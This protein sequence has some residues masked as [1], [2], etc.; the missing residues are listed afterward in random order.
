MKKIGL[1]F[2]MFVLLIL[3]YSCGVDGDP[4]H[5]YFSLEWEYYAEDY[6][7][8]YYRDNNPDVPDGADIVEKQYYDCYP[9]SYDYYYESE[10]PENWYTFE[11]VYNLVQNLGAPARIFEDGVDGVDTFFDLYLFVDP[12]NV[13]RMAVQNPPLKLLDSP[14]EF[15]KAD[16]VRVEDLSWEVI[17]DGWTLSV[18]Q[19]VSV[20][21]KQIED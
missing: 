13:Q 21:K 2:T 8:S 4:G 12:F 3:S 15:L 18:T 11:G 9:G 6:G 7:V 20:Y 5:C 14:R 17:E 19:K 1:V 16:P 10:N